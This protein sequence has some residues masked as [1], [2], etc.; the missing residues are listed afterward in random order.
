MSSWLLAAVAGPAKISGAYLHKLEHVQFSELA[1]R[2]VAVVS[3]PRLP[4]RIAEGKPDAVG[5]RLERPVE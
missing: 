3:R 2:F 1:A 4:L 5:D